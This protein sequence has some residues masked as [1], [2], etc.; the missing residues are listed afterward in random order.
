MTLCGAVPDD[1]TVVVVAD[2]DSGVCRAR[3]KGART[4]PGAARAQVEVGSSSCG[5]QRPV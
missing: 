5:S 3:L 2:G 1:V 4:G